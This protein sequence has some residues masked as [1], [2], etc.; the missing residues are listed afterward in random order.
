VNKFPSDLSDWVPTITQSMRF[1]MN[2]AAFVKTDAI[3]F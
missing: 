3:A 1:A 2:P